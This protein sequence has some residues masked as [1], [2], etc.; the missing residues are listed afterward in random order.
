MDLWKLKSV[1]SIPKADTTPRTLVEVR[2]TSYGRAPL[3]SSVLVASLKVPIER[4]RR[5]MEHT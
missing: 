5:D 1:W 4:S 3:E 2:N